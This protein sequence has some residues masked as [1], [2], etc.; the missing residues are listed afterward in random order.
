[1]KNV[2]INK[3][4]VNALETQAR[5]L[6]KHVLKMIHA[7]KSGHPGGSLSAADIVTVLYF[8]VMRLD[9]ARPDWCD[10]DRFILSKGHACPVWYSALAMRGFF[11]VA[12]LNTLRQ[13]GSILQGHPDMRKVPGLDMTT[14]CLGHGLSVAVGMGL[15]L[16][17]KKSDSRVYII[18]G[19][20]ELDEGQIWEA[21]MCAAK[22]RLDN[23]I[24][25]VDIDRQME[26]L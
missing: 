3:T 23:L 26:G 8:H 15:G 14:G 12:K 19:D 21:A 25:F 16:E 9:P 7:A 13:M 5:E 20:G 6:R 22:Y 2:P 11:D 1:M 17:F 4:V 10:R 24:A 18:L